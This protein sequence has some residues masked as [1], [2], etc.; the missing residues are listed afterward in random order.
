MGRCVPLVG[1]QL[2]AVTTKKCLFIFTASSLRFSK[3]WSLLRTTFST[4]GYAPATA[5]KPATQ[6]KDNIFSPFLFPYRFPLHLQAV[7]FCLSFWQQ[8]TRRITN[9]QSNRSSC[10]ASAERD[11]TRAE[12]RFRLSPK[13]TSPFKSVGAS[14]QSTAGSRG[15][16]ISGSNTG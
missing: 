13:R 5:A 15:L 2:L 8:I 10:I 9:W 12:T 3:T 14:V 7:T 16:R 6:N 1:V 11:G 4:T